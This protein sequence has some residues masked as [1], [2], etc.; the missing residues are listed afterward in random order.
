MLEM[1]RCNHCGNIV[2]MAYKGGAPLICCGEEMELLVAN[3]VDAAAEKHVPVVSREGDVVTVKV[4]SVEHPMIPEHFIGSI[5]LETK[6][7][8][9]T[10]WLKADD[11]PEAVFA[12]A[13]G[14]EPVA[15]YE[16]CTI[17]G[18][19]KAEI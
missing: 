6:G 13:P 15:A 18:L 5:L 1:Y 3:T 9:H 16:Y 12:L 2:I 7:A 19:W 8:L 4:G 11:K 14:E 17:H 10:R